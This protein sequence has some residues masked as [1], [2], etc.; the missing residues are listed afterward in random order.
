MQG[1]S[2]C[3]C[4]MDTAGERELRSSTGEL[5]LATLGQAASCP[6]EVRVQSARQIRF[7]RLARCLRSMGGG[8]D[9]WVE[10]A[11]TCLWRRRLLPRAQRDRISASEGAT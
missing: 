2:V 7:A 6:G 8:W 5:A 10:T 11:A 9:L 1:M 3:C 4:L